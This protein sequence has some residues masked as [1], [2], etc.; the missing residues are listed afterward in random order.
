MNKQIYAQDL[1]KACEAGKVL[2]EHGD[3]DGYET[4]G[5]TRLVEL[6]SVLIEELNRQE[7]VISTVY[8]IYGNEY[9]ADECKFFK[10]ITGLE[11]IATLLKEDTTIL[12]DGE[13]V[14]SVDV[15]M[16]LLSMWG[17]TTDNINMELFKKVTKIELED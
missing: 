17:Y 2:I 4:E 9:N 16:G 8:D 11:K 7:Q 3:N 5:E 14:K 10:V 6:T 15:K 13:E 1:L 12:Y